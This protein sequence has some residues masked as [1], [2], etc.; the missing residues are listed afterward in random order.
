MVRG[1]MIG[2]ILSFAD[3]SSSDT[4]A[5]VIT[6]IARSPITSP[7]ATTTITW[8]TNEHASSQ[9]EYGKTASLG[10]STSL[11]TALVRAHEVTLTGLDTNTTY[12]F[13]VKSSDAAGNT[14]TS[15]STTLSTSCS[16]SISFAE[17]TDSSGATVARNWTQ[18]NVSVNSNCAPLSSFV[19]WNRSLVGYWDGNENSGST[20]YDESTYGNKGTLRNGTQWTTGRFGSALKFDGV[21]DYAEIPNSTSLTITKAITIEAWVNLATLPSKMST[22]YPGYFG[23]SG[24][25]SFYWSKSTNQLKWQWYDSK[26]ATHSAYSA[27]YFQPDKWYHLVYSFDGKSAKGYVNGILESEQAYTG[28][29]AS[30]SSIMTIGKAGQA[31]KG[32][33]DEVRVWNRALSP[34][35]IAASYDTHS[36]YLPTTFSGLANGTYQ[37][38]AYATNAAGSSART[39]TRTLIVDSDSD[40]LPGDANNDGIVNAADITKVERIIVGLEATISPADANGDGKVDVADI[41]NIERAIA[42][43]S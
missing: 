18:V 27:T 8:T 35:E 10:L 19:D 26:G 30:S 12:Y 9:I 3:G 28:S 39:E 17:P 1:K 14:A 15:A 33:A 38:Y 21:D 42:G 2:Y 25:F 41:T 40:Q 13:R 7:L 37:Y 11:D 34:E 16:T 32:I 23:K 24:V 36:G 6:S 4:T 22:S 29:L 43:L 5:P 31:F 20:A